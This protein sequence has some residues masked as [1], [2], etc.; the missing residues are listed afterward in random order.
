MAACG[1]STWRLTAFPYPK[2]SWQATAKVSNFHDKDARMSAPLAMKTRT[3]YRS[4]PF[5]DPDPQCVWS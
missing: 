3:R 2:W 1:R 5:I 4:G